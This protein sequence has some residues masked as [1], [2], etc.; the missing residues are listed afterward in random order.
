[1]A[2]AA[3]VATAVV[4]TGCGAGRTVSQTLDPV[5]RAADVTSKLPGYRMQAE[6][7]M[8]TAGGSV[9]ATMSGVMNRA[10]RTGQITT[11]E[12][13]AGHALTVAERLS[14]LTLYMDAAGLPGVGNVTHGK[15]WLKLDMTRTLGALGLGSLSASS[16]DP[17]QFVDYLRAVSANTKRLGAETVRGVPTTHYR[18]VVDLR[19]YPNLVAPS[20]RAAAKR[21]ILALETALG[22]HTMAMDVWVG[23]DKLVRRLHFGYPEC[24][25]DQKLNLSMTMDLFDYGPQPKTQLPSDAQAFDLTPLLATAMQNIKL[26]CTAA[27]S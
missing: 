1:L 18:A 2:A 13:I 20:Q 22:S 12:D 3:A 7:T 17:S 6:M 27:S 11:H 25:N 4:I 21:G 9:Q 8:S 16:S 23:A 15:P 5:A 24:V 14:G 10:D 26:G 19:R